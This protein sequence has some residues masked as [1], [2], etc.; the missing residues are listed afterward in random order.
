LKSSYFL[1]I[2]KQLDY[3]QRL[4]DFES[5]ALQQWIDELPTAN[6]ALATRLILFPSLIQFI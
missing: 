6:P 5:K 4:R 3:P 1:V 2:P